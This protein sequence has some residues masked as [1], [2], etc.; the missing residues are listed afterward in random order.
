MGWECSASGTPEPVG[1]DRPAGTPEVLLQSRDA[2]HQ[3]PPSAVLND[4]TD[5]LRAA[6]HTLSWGVG[7][8]E[9]LADC[10][11]AHGRATGAKGPLDPTV[12]HHMSH[13]CLF[14]VR[15]NSTCHTTR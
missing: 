8:P 2:P 14:Y 1:S 4:P 9:L 10:Y 6:G 11:D 15:S 13:R 3:P 5:L 12:R 7:Y